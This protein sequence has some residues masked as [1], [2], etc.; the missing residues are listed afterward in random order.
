MALFQPLC[1]RC[2]FCWNHPFRGFGY[3]ACFKTSSADFCFFYRA[4]NDYSHCMKIRVKT[5]VCHVVCVTD[6]VSEH[7]A[8]SADIA[9][10]RH[11]DI[12][13]FLKKEILLRN[14]FHGKGIFYYFTRATW[15]SAAKYLI[16]LAIPWAICCRNWG[17]LSFRSPVLLDI[18]EVSTR[19]EGILAP[20]RT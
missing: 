5:P 9:F 16:P 1:G 17:L 8:F 4:F 18:N 14:T 3:L 10:H 11:I 20:W 19:M 15:F 6:A 13:L 7:G 2:N 12:P